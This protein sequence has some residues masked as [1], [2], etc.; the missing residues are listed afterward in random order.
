[1]CEEMED[2][3]ARTLTAPDSAPCS[4]RPDRETAT[5]VVHLEACTESTTTPGMAEV[6][7]R[8]ELRV[9]EVTLR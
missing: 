8:K 6:L 3:R 9:R 5:G 1:M 4:D 2:L 7:K